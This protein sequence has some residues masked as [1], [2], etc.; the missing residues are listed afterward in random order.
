MAGS[1]TEITDG[2]FQQEVLAAGEPVLVDFWAPWCGPCKAL[3][4]TLNQLAH[5]NAGKVKF[6]KVDVDNNPN[7][8]AQ[9]GVGSIPTLIL[10][11]KGQVI[12]QVMG[13]V[14]KPTI[15]ELLNKAAPKDSF[16]G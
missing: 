3:A 16:Q 14:P 9:F 1:V 5:E 8:A 4:P 11:Q 12:G 6:A 10:F 13:N 15:E 7:N 2:N